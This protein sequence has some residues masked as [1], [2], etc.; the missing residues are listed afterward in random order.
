VTGDCMTA[1]EDTTGIEISLKSKKDFFSESKSHFEFFLNRNDNYSI[2]YSKSGHQTKIIKIN[3]KNISKSRWNEGFLPIYYN[4]ILNPLDSVPESMKVVYSPLIKYFPEIDDFDRSDRQEDNSAENEKDLFT[5]SQLIGRWYFLSK[6]NDTKSKTENLVDGK[7]L[8]I[9]TNN[10]YESDIFNESEIGKWTFDK[11]TQILILKS[12]SG[13][14]QWKLKNLNEFG[15]V[16][17]NLATD[18]KWMFSAE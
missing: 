10:D 1:T 15:L 9:K 7:S 17:I 14:T 8:L 5:E 6:D 18:E 16:L 2:K 11:K 4:V 12:N 13:T 3:T